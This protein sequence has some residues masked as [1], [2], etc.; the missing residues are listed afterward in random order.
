MSAQQDYL[1]AQKQVENT[2][3]D[4]IQKAKKWFDEGSKV[5]FEN[6]PGLKSFSW[7]QYTP[8]FNDGDPC[9]FRASTNTY[10]IRINGICEDD[11]SEDDTDDAID[12]TTKKNLTK[13]I[14][15]FL[16]QFNKENLE[17]MFG[18]GLI[19]V[20]P[21]SKVIVQEYNHD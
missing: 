5:F 11:E 21:N 9:V 14:S 7:P 15:T 3:K 19:E 16:K 20:H 4:A 2:K 6:N 17:E 8:Y 12:A 13:E 10:S 18:E 1:D